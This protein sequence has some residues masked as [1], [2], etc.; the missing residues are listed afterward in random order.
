MTTFE[1]TLIID[2]QGEKAAKIAA[3]LGFVQYNESCRYWVVTDKGEAYMQQ[4]NLQDAAALLGSLL[5][6]EYIQGQLL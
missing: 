4:Y 3:K 5:E 6:P 1:F 2:A